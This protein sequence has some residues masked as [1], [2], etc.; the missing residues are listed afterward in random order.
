MIRERYLKLLATMRSDPES[1]PED[2]KF[3]SDCMQ[4]FAQYVMSVYE[5]QIGMSVVHDRFKG[6]AVPETIMGQ[7]K[8]R[9]G[10]HDVAIDKVNQLNRQ[11]ER[12]NIEPLFTGNSKDRQE[13]AE[14]CMDV[15]KE[16]FDA[17]NINRK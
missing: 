5:M 6:D 7:D 4:W 14:F 3:V 10:K 2:Y 8:A 1:E 11:C 9:R 17:R 15:V 13:V 16:F 12:Y